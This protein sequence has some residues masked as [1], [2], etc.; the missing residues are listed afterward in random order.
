MR[1]FQSNILAKDQSET[2]VYL[3]SL[4]HETRQSQFNMFAM[5]LGVQVSAEEAKA[6]I[7]GLKAQPNIEVLNEKQVAGLPVV[8]LK[9]KF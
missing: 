1:A 2:P 4:T 7:A 3:I 8:I 5:P 6:F 9:P